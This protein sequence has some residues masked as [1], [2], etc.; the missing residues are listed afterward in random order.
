MTPCG[1][2]VYTNPPMVI[3]SLSKNILDMGIYM[4]GDCTFNY[5]ISSLSKKCANLS[6]WIM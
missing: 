6:E 1:S 5:H 2:N 4:S 3:I